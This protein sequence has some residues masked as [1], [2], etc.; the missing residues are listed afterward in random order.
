MARV[1]RPP[2]FDMTYKPS[3]ATFLPPWKERAPALVYFGL[4]CAVGLAITAAPFLPDGSW[5]YQAVVV[6]DRT[7]IMP[8]SS[9][10]ILL[11]VSG[12][13]AM[14]RRYMSGV[15]VHP[16]GI[17]T[18]EVL[19]LG[20]PRV[21]KL[22]WAQIDRVAIPQSTVAVVRSSVTQT[23]SK[24]TKIRLDLWD[25]SHQFLPDVAKLPDLALMIERVALA[26]AIPIEG[27]TGMVD[28]LGSPFG[29]DE[30]EAA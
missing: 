14:L 21:K 25:G 17:E 18:R 27:G 30:E 1:S 23:P 13:A 16:D 12:L 15:V 6:G 10:A 28:D 22:R 8:S 24:V 4:V 26:R 7:R 5:L 20:V 3:K 19:P 2:G 11:F 9:F 29:E